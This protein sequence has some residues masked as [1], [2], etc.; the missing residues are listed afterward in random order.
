M[1]G[2]RFR[3]SLQNVL[4]LR[5]HELEEAKRTLGE[6]ERKLEEQRQRI[7]E[8]KDTLDRLSTQVSRTT[9]AALRNFENF[10][11]D[12]ERK[13]QQETRLLSSVERQKTEALRVLKLRNQS[14]E[15]LV[16]LRKAHLEAWQA[17]T[18]RVEQ[19]QLDE[20]AMRLHLNKPATDALS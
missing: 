8:A 12:A 5:A 10:R 17:E 19:E 13:V 11:R 14:Y 7:N 1:A 2:N 3:F 4:D 20:V 9:L 15:A 6:V 16:T 18:N